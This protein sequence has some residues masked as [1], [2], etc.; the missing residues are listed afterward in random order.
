MTQKWLPREFFA[1]PLPSTDCRFTKNGRT[2]QE[3]IKPFGS[4]VRMLII[5]LFSQN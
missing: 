2:G 5:T 3:E 1:R 4:K